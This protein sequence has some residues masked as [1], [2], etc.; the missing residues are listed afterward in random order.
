MTEKHTLIQGKTFLSVTLRSNKE[1]MFNKEKISNNKGKHTSNK[2][3]HTS[4][5]GKHTSNKVKPT[6][7]KGKP[8]SNKGKPISNK[9][10]NIPSK[11]ISLQINNRIF[12]LIRSP[13]YKVR[14][15]FKDSALIFNNSTHNNQFSNKCSKVSASKT[16]IT[17][18]LN[19]ILHL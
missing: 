9:G 15:E 18:S 5:K 11:G 12:N 2:G 17:V 6:S 10:S 14:G 16:P 13:N 19:K 3:K 8:T 1:R 7:N 4:N